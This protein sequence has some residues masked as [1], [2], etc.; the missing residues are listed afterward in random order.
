MDNSEQ[1]V[2]PGDLRVIGISTHT[3][4]GPVEP[5]WLNLEPGIAVLYGRN[6]T[7]KT[8]VLRTIAEAG[9]SYTSTL[10]FDSFPSSLKEPVHYLFWSQLNLET[11]ATQSGFHDGMTHF[12]DE[13]D[14][15]DF[16][17][18]VYQL[19]L[20]FFL[21]AL[22]ETQEISTRQSGENVENEELLENIRS[23]VGE[24]QPWKLNQPLQR[25]CANVGLIA[26]K[27]ELWIFPEEFQTQAII[28]IITLILH[29]N[30]AV[31]RNNLYL[32]DRTDDG[33]FKMFC[34]RALEGKSNDDYHFI[35]M[36]EEYGSGLADLI[37]DWRD[38]RQESP[39]PWEGV[40]ITT[41]LANPRWGRIVYDIDLNQLDYGSATDGRFIEEIC[42]SLENE[43]TSLSEDN[44]RFLQYEDGRYRALV[45]ENDGTSAWDEGATDFIHLI[46]DRANYYF[47]LFLESAPTLG[48]TQNPIV[49]W[50]D[51]SPVCWHT[52]TDDDQVIPLANLSWAE[53]RWASMAICLATPSSDLP[54]KLIVID[55][56]ERGLHRRAERT[57][58][59]ALHHLSITEN[60]TCV[61]ATHSPAFL[62]INGA[63]LNHLWK[64]PSGSSVLES[65]PSDIEPWA[66]ELGLE[67]ADL[68]QLCRLFLIV[69]GE[70]DALVL[71]TLFNDE[72]SQFGVRA[73][74]L[75][76]LRNITN[77]TDASFIFRYTDASILYL[78]DNDNH[79]RVTDIWERALQADPDQKFEIIKEFSA[80]R[81]TPEAEML[82]E[83]ASHAIDFSSRRRIKFS[84]LPADDILKYLPVTC[85]V[86]GQ[87]S[88]EDLHNQWK[89]SKKGSF[90]SW[91][92][93]TYGA[94]FDN[95]SILKAVESLDQIPKD[96]TDILNVI[97]ENASI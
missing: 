85:F 71:N 92:T 67:K 15:S 36:V 89:T 6:G 54:N 73:I 28:Q 24:Y 66:N 93:N 26:Y 53:Q 2:A 78:T 57:L 13:T 27:N 76:G 44:P 41:G 63:R 43:R 84:S 34:K 81:K 79:Q 94:K 20:Q 11:Q 23:Q 22:D 82:K 47:K 95:K 86:P 46:I 42:K 49:T 8:N 32:V 21:F 59:N 83:F 72:F 97:I 48:C 55:E 91:L 7:G 18:K 9:S 3:W 14:R 77:A 45:R 1:L 25:I 33:F 88:W 38:Y 52:V 68:L 12:L 4:V 31:T 50:A 29:Q 69:E 19:C 56:P 5:F 75:R 10:Y 96:L 87:T 37:D 65:L 70:H 61:V 17:K 62:G 74:P 39:A 80:T 58:A 51:C 35:D 30:Y 90:K 40:I 64:S 60:I 16:S